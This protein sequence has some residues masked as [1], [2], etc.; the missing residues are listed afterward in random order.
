MGGVVDMIVKSYKS[1]AGGFREAADR[2]GI[3]FPKGQKTHILRHSFASHF[4]MNGGGYSDT[5][6]S[7][8]S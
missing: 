1:T 2:S 7:T 6:K 5:S 4:M 3:E 8:R